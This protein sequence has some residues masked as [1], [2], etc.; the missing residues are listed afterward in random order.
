M[1][2]R[3]IGGIFTELGLSD[4]EP[5]VYLDGRILR[6]AMKAHDIDF[7][8]LERLGLERYMS[9]QAHADDVTPSNW[10]YMVFSGNTYKPCGGLVYSFCEYAGMKPHELMRWYDRHAGHGGAPDFIFEAELMD[11]VNVGRLEGKSREFFV[12][13]L[14]DMVSLGDRKPAGVEYDY[15]ALLGEA[16]EFMAAPDL[17]LRANEKIDQAY[18]KGRVQMHGHYLFEA[19]RHFTG[20]MADMIS[21]SARESYQHVHQLYLS[22]REEIVKMA[23]PLV[24]EAMAESYVRRLRDL[25][26]EHGPEHAVKLFEGNPHALMP[27]K[28]QWQFLILQRMTVEPQGISYEKAFFEQICERAQALIDIEDTLNDGFEDVDRAEYDGA[29]WDSVMDNPFTQ[30]FVRSRAQFYTLASIFSKQ[31]LVFLSS[32]AL[33]K[34]SKLGL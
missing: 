34:P 23:S 14:R 1:E 30:S 28:K 20:Y 25:V 27:L 4:I 10:L 11:A 8:V 12:Q 6:E 24:G 17:M 22:T 9:A 29:A 31:Q 33:L 26:A 5:N 13:C 3:G 32:K 19:I 18:I 7:D 21:D 15:N 2:S 16:L